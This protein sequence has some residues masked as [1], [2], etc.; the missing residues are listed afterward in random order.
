MTL[1][2]E[3]SA[4]RKIWIDALKSGEYKQCKNQ[5]HNGEGYCCLGVAKKV[6]PNIKPQFEEDNDALIYLDED[7]AWNYLGLEFLDQSRLSM[8]ND[9][10]MTFTEIADYIE[11]NL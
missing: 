11:N 4:N 9:D 2:P 6:I 8:M 1:T 5:L 10:G 3:Q 7:D